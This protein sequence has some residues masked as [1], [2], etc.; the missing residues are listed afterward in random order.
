MKT[1]EQKL[2]NAIA[3]NEIVQLERSRIEEGHLTGFITSVGR[4]I[5]VLNLVDDSIRPNGWVC[6]RLIDITD[7][8]VPY[9]HAA[10]VKR[11]LWLRGYEC[12]TAIELDVSSIANLLGAIPVNYRVVSIHCELNTPAEFWVG[13]LISIESEEVSILPLS[14]DANW[15]N[16]EVRLKLDDVTRV[17]FGGGYEEALASVAI[18]NNH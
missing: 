5:V 15:E 7:C 13:K 16:D 9:Q 2:R 3:T 18:S 1:L 8:D 11:A 6:I 14:P 17:D 10:F 12:Q 4:G